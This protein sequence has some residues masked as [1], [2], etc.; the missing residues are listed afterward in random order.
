MEVPCS[1]SFRGLDR[2]AALEQQVRE[3]AVKLQQVHNSISACRVMVEATHHSHHKGNIYHVRVEA[4]VPGPDVVVS[5]SQND[6]HA[7]EDAYVAIRDAFEAARRQLDALAGKQAGGSPTK[8]S[9][10]TR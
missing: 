6:N 10:V 2:S 1:I 3:K 9:R 5:N 7:H 8:H 4:S